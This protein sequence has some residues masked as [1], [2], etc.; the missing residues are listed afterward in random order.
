M[1]TLFTVA[2]MALCFLPL[3]S[4]AEGGAIS[5]SRAEVLSPSE[6]TFEIWFRPDGGL[7]AEP[8][9]DF[10]SP[11]QMLA[12]YAANGRREESAR[13]LYRIQRS[14]SATD[15]SQALLQGMVADAYRRDLYLKIGDVVLT[16][17]A[18]R[19]K[20]EEGAWHV[21][22]ATWREEGSELYLCLYLDGRLLSDT[23]Q[24]GRLGETGEGRLVIGS[25]NAANPPLM[26]VA[27]YRFSRRALSA[28]ELEAAV[29][30]RPERR[31]ETLLVE[32]FADLSAG[33]G[34]EVT[35]PGGGTLSGEYEI[36]KGEHGPAVQLHRAR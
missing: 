13:L 6:G 10:Y 8:D 7:H 16:A 32:T 15:P 26:T 20:L 3:I 19:A 30:E 34:G 12:S 2:A 22:A 14:K 31:E 36:V 27:A 21:L 23:R 29:H 18:G 17:G 25:L 24:S 4:T 5:L 35:L 9:T 11:F 1:K 33:S 28:A